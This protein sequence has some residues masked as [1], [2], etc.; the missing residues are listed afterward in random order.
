MNKQTK[1]AQLEARKA[2]AIATA[3][4]QEMQAK[5]YY[6][7]AKSA[8]FAARFLIVWAIAR[9]KELKARQRYEKAQENRLAIARQ[10]AAILAAVPT[11]YR[12]INTLKA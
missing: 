7:T 11:D 10:Y 6:E 4:E 3:K 2:E 12:V 1:M 8:R 5:S 9:A